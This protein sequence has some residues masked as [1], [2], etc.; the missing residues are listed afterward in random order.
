MRILLANTSAFP[1]IGGVENSLGY[2]ARELHALGHK[3]QV[4]CLQLGVD[5]PLHVVHEQVEYVRAPSV[6]SRWPH[7]RLWNYVAAVEQAAPAV[8]EAFRPNV[9]WSRSASVAL[10]IRRGGYSGPLVQVFCTNA[11]MDSGGTYLQTHGLP[12]HR[13]L[14]LL[15]LWPL[16][17]RA[18]VQVERELAPQCTSVAF[19]EHMRREL[20]ADFPSEAQRCHVIPPGVDDAFFSPERGRAGFNRLSEEFGLRV[21]DPTVL[22]VGRLSTAKHLTVLVD[23]FAAL[24]GSAKLVFVGSGP[25]E[26]RLK[27]RA[28][29]L[30]VADRVVFAGT[31]RELLPAFYAAARVFVLPTTTESF[32]QVYLEALACG[33]PAVGFGGNGRDV[34]TATDE[35]VRH[36]ET[37]A[38]ARPATAAALAEEIGAVL[39][40]DDAAYGSM[41]RRARADVRTRYSWRRFV[42]R[43]LSVSGPP[44]DVMTEVCEAPCLR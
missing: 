5:E 29:A 18:A 14:L 22:Y 2:I 37:G 31:Q 28:K 17:Y 44:T 43:A 30:G 33:T 4:F 25:E 27:A 24:D 9:V 3:V 21:G 12:L 42:E 10:G 15:G 26:G 23:A 34:L 13:R 20:L 16:A 7:T 38:V 32:G 8:I 19:S 6:R 41:S 35:I 11:R 40:L 39:S 1:Q 36:G